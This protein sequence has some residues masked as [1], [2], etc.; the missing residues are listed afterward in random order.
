MGGIR[1]ISPECVEHRGTQILRLG[2]VSIGAAV[3][4]RD[5]CQAKS[6]MAKW[7]LRLH[8]GALSKDLRGQERVLSTFCEPG[9][10]PKSS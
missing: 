6:L 4:C 7:T 1:C 10:L 2:K 9:S 5:Q 3:G 8:L